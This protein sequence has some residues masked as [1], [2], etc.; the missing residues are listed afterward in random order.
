MFDWR[1]TIVEAE[2]L[3]GRAAKFLDVGERR[4]A[5]FLRLARAEQIE[6]GSVEDV[7]GFRPWAR[8][9]RSVKSK[10][11]KLWRFIGGPDAQGEARTARGFKALFAANAWVSAAAQSITSLIAVNR[12]RPA[13][14]ALA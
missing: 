7:D 14:L 4:A 6:I 1:N 13:A 10:R 9:G 3:G 11:V 12:C 2:A 5:V 8:S